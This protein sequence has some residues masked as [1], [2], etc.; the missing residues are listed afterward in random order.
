MSTSDDPNH[1]L[2]IA[3]DPQKKRRQDHRGWEAKL[4]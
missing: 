3:G 4:Y 2:I 1:L